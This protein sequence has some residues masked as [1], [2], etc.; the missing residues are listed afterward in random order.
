MINNLLAGAFLLL[1]A[2]CDQG[3]EAVP[4]GFQGIVELEE[5]VLGFEVPGRIEEIGVDRGSVVE[6][7]GELA[8]LDST[9]E[10][11]SRDAKTAEL[12][13]LE[14]Q[15]DLL[16]EGARPAEIRATA[17][18]LRA[19]RSRVS[20]LERNL[21]RQQRLHA[22]HAASESVVDNLETEL[23]TQRARAATI[24]NRLRLVRDG[25]RSQEVA[26]AEAQ[27][28]AARAGLA[29]VNERLERYRIFAE[30][31]G[32][33]L[34]RHAEPGEVVSPG[35]PVITLADPTRP[36]VEVFVP[37]GEI[38]NVSVGMSAKVG[39]DAIEDELDGEVESIGRRTEFTPRYI[40]SER[41]RPNLVVRVRIRIDDPEEQLRAGVPAFARLSE[42]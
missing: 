10:E 6:T 35:T 1:S 15:L 40:F 8:R 7:N 30:L 9:L 19:A 3:A 41:E 23:A 32:I 17:A 12:A 31:P 22:A 18:E 38:G 14:A 13:A 16:R 20:L 34:D 33:V 2:G 29:A 28:D 4:E 11:I 5:V 21:A 27:V 39:I 26:A 42:T 25:A 36:F 24:E 37:E